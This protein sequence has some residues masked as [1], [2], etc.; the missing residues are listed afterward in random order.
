MN[1]ITC[2]ER[3]PGAY[4][5]THDSLAGSTASRERRVER[6]FL[7]LR[8]SGP[9][10]RLWVQTQVGPGERGPPQR[11]RRPR[12]PALEDRVP[13]HRPR[14]LPARRPGPHPRPQ[15]HPARHPNVTA[16][17]LDRLLTDPEPEAAEDAAANPMLSRARM[18]RILAEASL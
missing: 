3:V 14:G 9:V 10:G 13:A 5:D 8:R 2:E 1:W 17:L 4:R 18:D 6:S 11:G 15:T 16:D 7:F 12:L